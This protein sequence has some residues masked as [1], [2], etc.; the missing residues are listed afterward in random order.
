MVCA[1]SVVTLYYAYGMLR[2]ARSEALSFMI[3]ARF[4]GIAE[5]S[6]SR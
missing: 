1:A 4:L 3:V 2:A 5:W 6:E